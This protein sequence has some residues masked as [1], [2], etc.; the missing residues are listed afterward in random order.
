MNAEGEPSLVG[1]WRV[2]PDHG[3]T[4]DRFGEVTLHF[5]DDGSLDYVVA[6]AERDQVMQLRYR[7]DGSELVTDQPSAPSEE[8]TRFGFTEE[9]KLALEYDGFMAYYVRCS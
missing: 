6:G 7:V 1:S 4:L 2:D 9:G 8:R 5:R 3:A